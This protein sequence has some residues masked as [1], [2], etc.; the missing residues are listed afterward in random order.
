MAEVTHKL[1]VE[2]VTPTGQAL[3]TD[4]DA[5]DL[6]SVLGEFE[7]LPGHLPVLV[8]LKA[9]A[10]RWRQGLKIHRAALGEGFAEARPD[11]VIVL[12][13]RYL[14][15]DQ[16]DPATASQELAAVEEKVKGW[17]GDYTGPEYGEVRRDHEWAQARVDVVSEK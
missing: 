14:A 17:T 10:F 8:A 4:A 2:V 11:A 7:V 9:G 15:A 3:K 1:R 13:D 12:A 5:V 6:A 16:I